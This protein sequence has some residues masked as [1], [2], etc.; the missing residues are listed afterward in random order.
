MSRKCLPGHR[1]IFLKG[2][3]ALFQTCCLQ[4]TTLQSPAGLTCTDAME[5]FFFVCLF[6]FFLANFTFR[7]SIAH[8]KRHLD[9]EK[10]TLEHISAQCTTRMLTE[11][12]NMFH[13]KLP[14][15]KME[16]SL[17]YWVYGLQWRCHT[18]SLRPPAN[19][20]DGE[21]I[22]RIVWS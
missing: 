8:K 15:L 19:K 22:Q 2:I 18:E 6:F 13:F 12:P 5:H 10:G 20:M 21:K 14:F 17:T 7:P 1:A 3:Q 16:T 11:Q 4:T 9:L